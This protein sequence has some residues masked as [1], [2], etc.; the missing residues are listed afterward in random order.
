MNGS[1]AGIATWASPDITY[2]AKGSAEIC[3]SAADCRIAGGHQAFARREVSIASTEKRFSLDQSRWFDCQIA[4]GL[5]ADPPLGRSVSETVGSL[6][7]A[8]QAA[9]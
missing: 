3:R 6:P 4:A 9:A 7:G 5:P 8:L 1:Q 2:L